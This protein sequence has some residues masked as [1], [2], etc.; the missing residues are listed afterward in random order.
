MLREINDRAAIDAL[1]S[2]G[3]LTRADLEEVIGL[4]KP[5]TAQLLTRLEQDGIVVKAGVRG[6]GRGPRAQLWAVDG[7][8]ATVAAVDLTTHG[9]DFVLADVTGA[10]LA[11]HR[12]PLPAEGALE[13]FATA[14]EHA[15]LS[16]GVPLS[17]L[18]LMVIGAQGAFNPNTGHLAPASAPHLPSWSG[19]DLPERLAARLGIEVTVENDVNLVALQEMAVGRARGCKNFALVWLDEGVGGA[20]VV[21]GR[22]LRG[23]T[24]GGGEIDWMR[25]PDPAVADTGTPKEGARFGN[26]VDYPAIRK[27]AAAHGIEAADGAE[28]VRLAMESEVDGFVGDLA[29]RVAV[30][31]AG[32]VSLVDPEVVLLCG[33]VSRV[34]GEPFA[35]AVAERLHRLVVPRTPVG[36]TAIGG[37]AVRAGALRSALA[38]VRE[39]EFGLGNHNTPVLHGPYSPVAIPP[40]PT[41]E[42]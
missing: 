27:L 10:V 37:N 34:A 29:A 19:F 24:G 20:V 38:Y 32:I 1:L 23:A 31:V 30:G 17:E 28:A 42:L 18:S 3:P 15:A 11:E 2:A 36:V 4:S 39:A 35:A 6:G 41:A 12:V 21:D 33:E 7:K 14:A 40:F 5:A 8:L 26:L 13:V 22:L 9:A 16:A 25:V